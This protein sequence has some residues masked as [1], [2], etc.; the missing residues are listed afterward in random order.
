MSRMKTKT[1][2]RNTG[3]NTNN[4]RPESK[5]TRPRLGLSPLK[6]K[7]RPKYISGP[8]FVEVQDQSHTQDKDKNITNNNTKNGRHK[9]PKSPKYMT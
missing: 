4:L 9:S 2:T 6:K 3:A 8:D 1:N 7:D 5:W